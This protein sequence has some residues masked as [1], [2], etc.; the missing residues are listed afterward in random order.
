MI[1]RILCFALCLVFCFG[2]IPTAAFATEGQPE[3]LQQDDA[4]WALDV[5]SEEQ[6]S[7]DAADEIP[8]APMPEPE[9]IPEPAPEP[10]PEPEPIPEPIT[11]PA[12]EPIP[13]PIPEPVQDPIQEPVQEQIPATAEPA[14]EQVVQPEPEEIKEEKEPEIKKLKLPSV[15]ADI[16]SLEDGPVNLKDKLDWHDQDRELF[17]FSDGSQYLSEEKVSEDSDEYKTLADIMEESGSVYGTKAEK[18]GDYYFFL[19]PAE[20]CVF[21]GGEE[22]VIYE[23]TA[24]TPVKEEVKEESGDDFEP[25]PVLDVAG[26]EKRD[27]DVEP[28]DDTNKPLNDNY[29][30]SCSKAGVSYMPGKEL[31]GMAED[32]NEAAQIAESYG[33]ELVNF[34]AG[35]AAYHTSEDPSSVIAYGQTNSLPPLEINRLQSVDGGIPTIVIYSSD[36]QFIS[37]GA[38]ENLTAVNVN[39][40]ALDGAQCS[41]SAYGEGGSQTSVVLSDSY[42]AGLDEGVYSI[43][44]SFGEKETNSIRFYVQEADDEE[45]AEPPVVK[46]NNSLEATLWANKRGVTYAL[47]RELYCLADS[48]DEAA[49]IAEQYGIELMEFDEGVAT[50]HTEDNPS[51]V[52]AYGEENGLRHLEINRVTNIE[53]HP[54]STVIYSADL[55][56]LSDGYL[57]DL[58]AVL[59]DGNALLNSQY[60]CG[61]VAEAQLASDGDQLGGEIAPDREARMSIALSEA[62][63]DTLDEIHNISVSFGEHTTGSVRVYFGQAANEGGEEGGEDEI[64][65]PNMVAPADDEGDAQDIADFY[66]ITFVSF[67]DGKAYYVAEDPD[68]VIGDR[69][70][71]AGPAIYKIGEE[72]ADPEPI[73]KPE[74]IFTQMRRSAEAISLSDWIDFEEGA[75]IAFVSGENMMIDDTP[76]EDLMADAG[77]SYPQSEDLSIANIGKYYVV[78]VPDEGYVFEDGD[79]FVLAQLE[80]TSRYELLEGEDQVWL[81]GSEDDGLAFRIDG[82]FAAYLS[83]SVDNFQLGEEDAD[84]W[85]GSTNVLIKAAKLDTLDDGI[86]TAKFLFDDIEGDNTVEVKFAVVAPESI[87][88]MTVDAYSDDTGL[89]VLPAI[90]NAKINVAVKFE[91]EGDAS[92]IVKLSLFN[93]DTG[94]VVVGEDGEEVSSKFLYS[95]ETKGD[96][97][98]AVL[99]VDTTKL[100]GARLAVKAE[101]SYDPDAVVSGDGGYFAGEPKLLDAVITEAD[102]SE[103]PMSVVVIGA[104]STVMGIHVAN[105]S[106]GCEVK[107]EVDVSGIVAG[108]YEVAVELFD[109]ETGDSIVKESMP[110]ELVDDESSIEAEF[111]QAVDASE[112][113]G[114]NIIAKVT[115]EM[116]GEVLD[117]VPGAEAP[118]IL[119][120]ET[121]ESEDVTIHFPNIYTIAKINGAKTSPAGQ[122]VTIVDTLY[123]ENLIPGLEYF[124]HGIPVVNENGVAGESLAPKDYTLIPEEESGAVEIEYPFD[125]SDLAGKVV[126]VTEEIRTNSILVAKHD[127]L[128]DADQMVYFSNVATKLRDADGNATIPAD[129]VQLIDKVS[130]INLTEGEEYTARGLLY[131]NGDTPVADE[132]GDPVVVEYQFV[133]DADG[134]GEF[135]LVYDI[136]A[137]EYAGNTIVAFVYITDGDNALVASHV[138]KESSVQTVY[139]PEIKTYA[140][141]GNGGKKIRAEG[142]DFVIDAVTYKSL[143]PNAEYRL[144]ATLVEKE[145]GEA[146]SEA[147]ITFRARRSEGSV[148][149]AIEFDAVKFLGK[150]LVVFEELYAGNSLVAEH[151]DIEDEAQTVLVPLSPAVYKYDVL[152]KK[153]LEGAEILIKDVTTGESG[154]VVTDEEG[155]AYFS[156]LDGHQYSYKETKAPEGYVI[157]PNTYYFNVGA[158]GSVS[159]EAQT[160]YNY[161]EGT[162]IIQ[163][164]DVKTGKPVEGATVTIYNKGNQAATLVTDKHGQ[165]YFDASSYIKE[166]DASFTY[167]ETQAPSGYYQ[168]SV[169]HKFSVTKDGKASGELSFV[170]AP[171]GT[172]TITKTDAEGH[173][174]AGARISIYTSAGRMIGQATTNKSGHIY[175][176]AP[177]ANSYYFIEDQ[178]P[179]GYARS[180]TKYPF[181]IDRYGRISGTTTFINEKTEKK[182]VAT[183]DNDELL[184][185]LGIFA[186]AAMLAIAVI[187]FCVV[188]P[189]KAAKSKAEADAADKKADAE[190]KE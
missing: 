71:L 24:Y 63:A 74:V 29:N 28:K 183:G 54:V 166:G 53:G 155:I 104:E 147:E 21:E 48:A 184:K 150:S 40:S 69:D 122:I 139:V 114:K 101:L 95:F 87:P 145:S 51:D 112:F 142:S 77:Y 81:I 94:D 86:H 111:I 158:D 134:S 118:M 59:V 110:F 13:E 123:Y 181:A 107:T 103:N 108:E 32:E 121:T 78:I 143:K 82:D 20:N 57:D 135:D 131:V 75:H 80:V 42:I 140:S 4:N 133:A 182:G 109:S 88:T 3:M 72:P 106:A 165:I 97:L 49:E 137:S 44:L 126:S 159:K 25:M 164:V 174:L 99:G 18:D 90:Q 33:I 100:I 148:E 30:L 79:E 115:V 169:E 14:Q 68:A 189:K 146:V 128:E 93:V 91:N 60:I 27:G 39:G 144:L 34:D 65:D 76:I 161:V 5:S 92:Y 162:V 124:I 85:E 151:A 141:N 17:C 105:A 125:S 66:G 19:T 70:S 46:E 38:S 98:D 56:F 173:P 177:E 175:F 89:Y 41:I 47:G 43:S 163:K 176:A 10:E 157:N 179:D 73:A 9:V 7:E 15:K 138:D 167:K 149:I 178:A 23:F 102:S 153:P 22:Y 61:E 58:T 36:V 1:K 8:E 185:Y 113:A 45:P 156:L 67:E 170:N 16:V 37:N 2:L 186:V 130:Y 171:L 50:F 12:P 11:E 187:V 152:T 168:D 172:V 96:E 26:E 52:V 31:I 180:D 55:L 120:A 84:A 6:G 116:V 119:V 136:D 188:K 129:E 127:D 35:V 132:N 62:Y 190:A 154:T 64:G 83:T 117:D 160:L